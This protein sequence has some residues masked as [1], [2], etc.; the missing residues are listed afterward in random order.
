MNFQQNSEKFVL[1][2]N[3]EISFSH[4]DESLYNPIKHKYVKEV[5]NYK[6]SS[7]RMRLEKEGIEELQM[8]FALYD[9]RDLEL[10]DE[11]NF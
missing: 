8:Q 5:S 6:W 1:T 3:R 9:Y 10:G 2:I 4:S 11:D 7:F